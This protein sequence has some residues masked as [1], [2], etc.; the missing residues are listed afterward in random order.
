MDDSLPMTIWNS[1]YNLLKINSSFLL[2]KFAFLLEEL[3]EFAPLEILHDDDELHVFEGI[4]VD[5]FDNV[6]MTKWFHIFCLS[7]NHVNTTWRSGFV[8]FDN[9]DGCVLARYV[10]FPQRNTSES[11]FAEGLDYFVLPKIFIRIEIF[12]L[13]YKNSIPIFQVQ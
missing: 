6:R 10:V 7:K 1:A 2:C 4:A 3:P 5:N 8:R 11:S 9:F 13:A 12:S